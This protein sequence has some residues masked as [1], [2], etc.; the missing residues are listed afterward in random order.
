MRNFFLISVKNLFS[1]ITD[2]AIECS[3]MRAN[4]IFRGAVDLPFFQRVKGAE[5]RVF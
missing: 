2:V 1:R 5:S 4:R 3:D